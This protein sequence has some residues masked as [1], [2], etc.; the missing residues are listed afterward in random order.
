MNLYRL[1][2]RLLTTIKPTYTRKEW[3]KHEEKFWKYKKII[4]S[5]HYA[6]FLKKQ[7]YVLSPSPSEAQN[8][9]SPVSEKTNNKVIVIYSTFIGK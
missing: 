9:L 1:N 8:L 7:P 4:T 2:Q 5:P 6:Y 3:K